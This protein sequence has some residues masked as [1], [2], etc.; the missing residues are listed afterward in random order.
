[1]LPLFDLLSYRTDDRRIF[2]DVF[3]A[4]FAVF[5]GFEVANLSQ[6]PL[7][8]ILQSKNAKELFIKGQKCNF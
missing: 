8:L 1:M 2:S 3:V 7:Q 4:D 6:L 5:K